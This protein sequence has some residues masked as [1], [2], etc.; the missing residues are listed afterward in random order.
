LIALGH[1]RIAFLN[2]SNGQ[3]AAERLTAY[4]EVLGEAGIAFDPQLVKQIPSMVDEGR[5][6]MAALLPLKP[7]AVFTFSDFQALGAMLAAETAGLRVPE[8]LSI[9]SFGNEAEA[10]GKNLTTVDV[11]MPTLGTSATD[12]LV[13]RINGQVE[14]PQTLRV[15]CRLIVGR[16]TAAAPKD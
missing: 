7:T 5:H 10:F 6:A 12:L 9:A 4:H 3:S 14:H 13:Q 8:D 16:T 1:R 2:S 15:K 11:N